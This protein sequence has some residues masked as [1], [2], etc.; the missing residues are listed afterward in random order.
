MPQV[1]FKV[2]CPTQMG[3][4]VVVVGGYDAA[5]SWQ[6]HH[7]QIKL[8]TDAG[9][10][11]F[12][13]GTTDLPKGFT[14][15]FKFAVL[16]SN[17]EARW[18]DCIQ[19]RSIE[20]PENAEKLQCHAQFNK[21]DLDLAPV[22]AVAQPSEKVAPQAASEKVAPQAPPEPKHAVEEP[23]EDPKVPEIVQTLITEEPFLEA[24]E[25][26]E[27]QEAADEQAMVPQVLEEPVKQEIVLVPE[28]LNICE[29]LTQGSIQEV[30]V[31]DNEFEDAEEEPI[32][33]EY[34][35]TTVVEAA[36]EAVREPSSNDLS[37]FTGA[38]VPSSFMGTTVPSGFA[39]SVGPSVLDEPSAPQPR[40]EE[41]PKKEQ[42][43][44]RKGR[45]RR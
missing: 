7:S 31:D 19:N 27:Q 6:P 34:V 38:T 15:D 4:E 26:P 40:A 22:K 25:E 24:L 9:T 10:Y 20:V 44:K 45:G 35:P 32:T 42:Q 28:Q 11:P 21:Q 1:E 39:D 5:G 18:E 12:W 8:C 41:L 36:P 2:Q 23:K 16:G 33:Q 37:S 30:P 17:K 13:A 14:L 43:A 3:E 29:D